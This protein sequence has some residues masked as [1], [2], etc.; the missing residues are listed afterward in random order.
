LAVLTLP[1]LLYAM[2][3]T[4]MFS[5][6]VGCAGNVHADERS[7]AEVLGD[8]PGLELTGADQPGILG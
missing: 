5:T 2:N 8:K 6:S 3:L 1:C 4:V 7:V